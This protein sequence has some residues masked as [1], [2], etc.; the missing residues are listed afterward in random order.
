MLE[1][2]EQNM[3]ILLAVAFLFNMA[4]I[5]T[6]E[7]TTSSTSTSIAEACASEIDAC[8]EGNAE[9]TLCIAALSMMSASAVN[10]PAG[11]P[12]DDVYNLVC[13]T[14]ESTSGCD[15]TDVLFMDV[16]N[17]ISA[18]VVEGCD[19]LESCNE[20]LDTTQSPTPLMTMSPTSMSAE[21][22]GT[23]APAEGSGEAGDSS[24][25]NRLVRHGGWMA[26]TSSLGL[27]FAVLSAFAT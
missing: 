11:T 10:V 1:R 6:I 4:N 13:E 3:R 26:I 9:C 14:M 15:T 25:A 16:A 18:N 8:E 19:E 17:C 23:P 22:D 12:C 7:A 2:L 5:V 24:S 27:A 20:Y 21:G